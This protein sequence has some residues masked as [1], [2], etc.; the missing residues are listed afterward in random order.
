MIGVLDIILLVVFI[1][2][3]PLFV[4]LT[5]KKN[6]HKP[7]YWALITLAVGVGFQFVLPVII[8]I[9]LAIVLGST[10]TSPNAIQ[11]T[12]Q[13][14]S[15]IFNISS[16]ILNVIGVLLILRRVS[17]I[18]NIEIAEPNVSTEN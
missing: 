17:K 7:V 12:I 14:Y 3:A 16:S 13:G 15:L 8:G 10:G 9:V 5:A 11:A 6:G 4:Y 18:N 2:I 1:I